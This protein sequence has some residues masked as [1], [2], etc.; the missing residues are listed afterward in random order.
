MVLISFFLFVKSL[1]LSKP[2]AQG[3]FKIFYFP[4]ILVSDKIIR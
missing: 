1:N 4:I 3:Y 2:A